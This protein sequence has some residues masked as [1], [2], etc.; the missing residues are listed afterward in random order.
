MIKQYLSNTN[1]ILRFQIF[2]K[3]SISKQGAGEKTKS[4]LHSANAASTH[5]DEAGPTHAVFPRSSLLAGSGKRKEM[6]KI[7]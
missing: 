6:S 5:F 2:Q 7:I 1:E 4:S 3:S